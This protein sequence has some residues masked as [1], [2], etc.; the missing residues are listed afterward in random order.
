MQND[1]FDAIPIPKELDSV[2]KAGIQEGIREQKRLRR[3]RIILR[4]SAVAA[5]AL[6]AICAGVLLVS[7]P[8]LAAKLPLVGRI[9]SMVQEKVSYKGDFSN[10]AEVYVEEDMTHVSE[11][12]A[13]AIS[14]TS[15][16]SPYVQTS[17]GLT[18]TISEANGSTQAV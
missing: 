6:I 17:N 13:D 2:V 10:N 15:E 3:S 1:R 12:E 11:G 16:G 5:A 8:S 7:D 9:F 4:Y 18:V 14:G